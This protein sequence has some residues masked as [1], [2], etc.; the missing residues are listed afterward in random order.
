MDGVLAFLA[1][2]CSDKKCALPSNTVVCSLGDS[3]SS[4]VVLTKGK[5]KVYR[6]AQDGRHITLY[7]INA[8]E[9]C[10]LTAS[11]LLNEQPFPAI[12]VTEEF[13]EGYVIAP[14]IFKSWLDTEPV[15]R[16]FIFGLLSQRMGDLIMKV[17]QLA[18][19]S[20][21]TRLAQWL[22]GRSQTPILEVTHQQIAQ[23]LASSR[24]VISR[25]LKRLEE[26]GLI[27]L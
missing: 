11:C 21:E 27:K 20:L 7:R 23:E 18:F 13:C 26:K 5:V 15:W 1:K 22:S 4:L 8:G 17:D 14:S 6:V 2:H 16:A 19:D 9:G 25:S 24:E 12:A 10:V 3:C